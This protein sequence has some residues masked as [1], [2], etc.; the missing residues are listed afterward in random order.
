M[1]RYDEIR[2]LQQGDLCDRGVG[3]GVI[4]NIRNMKGN[5]SHSINL[6]EMVCQGRAFAPLVRIFIQLTR[7]LKGHLFRATKENGFEWAELDSPLTIGTYQAAINGVINIVAPA[8]DQR[9]RSTHALR[10][11]GFTCAR[12]SGMPIEIAN[13]IIGHVSTDMWQHYYIPSVERVNYYFE[14]MGPPLELRR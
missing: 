10:K 5:I 14:G 12:E 9:C 4:Y 1:R 13:T 3:N 2:T 7:N 11:G 8:T 6:S